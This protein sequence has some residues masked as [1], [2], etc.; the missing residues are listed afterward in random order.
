[1]I[2]SFFHK[3]R[4][5]EKYMQIFFPL[6]FFIQKKKGS[7]IILF[8]RIM[9]TNNKKVLDK[10]GK[11]INLNKLSNKQTTW[12]PFLERNPN[13]QRKKIVNARSKF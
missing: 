5:R 6:F 13:N 9:M 1:M 11:K 8:I 4:K 10:A 7:I 2:I 12:Q 3:E